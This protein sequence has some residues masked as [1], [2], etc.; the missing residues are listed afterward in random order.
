MRELGMVCSVPDCGRPVNARGLCKRHYYRFSRYGDPLGTPPP[1]APKPPKP[2]LPCTIEGCDLPQYGR[3]WCE[4]HYARWRRHGS[5]HDKRAERRDALERFE[6]KVDRLT[7]PDGCHLWTGPPNGAG[8]GWFKLDGRTVGA[9]VAA[10]LLAS[11]EV[12][13]GH[14][15]DHLCLVKLCVRLDHLEV[16]TSVENKRRAN[17]LRDYTTS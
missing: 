9:H 15:P 4:N 6:E 14:E 13:P 7:T 5:T 1:R 8:Y 11:V 16:V 10:C 12:P 3:G 17:R 2:K